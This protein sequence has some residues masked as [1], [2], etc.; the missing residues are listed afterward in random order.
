MADL[1]K[2]LMQRIPRGLL[3]FL[4][5]KTGG[6]YPTALGG[7]LQPTIDLTQWYMTGAELLT[8]VGTVVNDATVDGTRIDITITSP[9]D[10]ADG[11]E[12]RVPQTE[13]WLIPQWTVDP[14][15]DLA[16]GDVCEV[17]PCIAND[18][19]FYMPPTLMAGDR[20]GAIG[21]I[22]QDHFGPAR[23]LVAFPPGLFVRPGE[24][25]QM[26]VYQS[27]FPSAAS[28]LPRSR[29]QLLRFRI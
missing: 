3:G 21:V 14:G 1:I 11:S 25:V 23:S 28:V 15:V 12:L 10:F 18:N 22:G 4:D 7:L 17:G 6:T 29:F 5:V 24:L 8:G 2:G 27:L 20:Q 16:G 19:G 13:I 26:M 9:T